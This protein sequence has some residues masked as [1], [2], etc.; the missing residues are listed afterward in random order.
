MLSIEN[1][2]RIEEWIE[3][4]K[5]EFIA[6][7]SK[8]IAVP[9]VATPGVAEG[10]YPFGVESANVL[11][12]AKELV[13]GYGFPV[14]NLENYCLVANVGEG[15][16]KIGIFGHLDVVPCGNDWNYPPYQL[17]VEGDLLIGRGILDDKGPLWASIYAVRCLKE[18]D[19]LPKREIE[20][21]MGG[22]EECGMNDVEYYIEKSEKLPEASFTPDGNYPLCHGEKGGLRFYLAVPCNDAKIVD[23]SGGTVRNVVADKCTATLKDVCAKC[24][25]EKLACNERISVETDGDLVKVTA[26]G[27]SVHASI[28]ENGINAIGVLA[29]ALLDAKVFEGEAKAAMEFLALV[30][31]DY[32]GAALGVPVE[33]EPSG[34]LTHVGGVINYDRGLLD[35]SID[36]RYPV[37]EKG[38]V[39]LEKIIETV[40]PYGVTVHDVVNTNPAYAPADSELVRTCMKVI[41]SVFRR[42]HW[43]PYTMGGGTYAKHLPNACALGPEDPDYENPFGLFRGSIHQAD[44]HTPAKL[45]FDT[46]LVYAKL[47]VEL[48]DIDVTK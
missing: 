25:A 18:L 26:N 17:T 39:L 14:K 13:E 9:S 22:Q 36:I 21:F 37:T 7:L 47:L 29:N 45:L 23:F 28:P 1:E 38:D 42:D 24:L 27:A 6:D 20:I 4:H 32:N 30:N 5:N 33:D 8:I 40:E 19:L 31:S 44:E 10:E 11:A 3:A 43:K 2:K 35:L 34:K 48:D 46:M 41:H 16:E 12:A 15:E